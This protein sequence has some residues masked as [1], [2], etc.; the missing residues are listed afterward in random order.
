[1]SYGL[2]FVIVVDFLTLL[3]F[4]YPFIFAGINF[5]ERY[6]SLVHVKRL[7]AERQL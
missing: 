4:W 1:M 5:T 2:T 3:L 6:I 7:E